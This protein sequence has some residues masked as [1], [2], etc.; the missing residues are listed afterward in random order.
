MVLPSSASPQQL[1]R[2]M[3]SGDQQAFKTLWDDWAHKVQ[4]FVRVQL[5]PSG[6]DAEHCAQEVVADVFHDL[7]RHPERFDG[8]VA[9]NTWLFTVARNKAIDRLRQHQRRSVME[10]SAGDEDFSDVPDDAPT[11]E[12]QLDHR[13]QRHAVMRCLERLRNHLQ[14]EAL[15][16]WAIDD[17]PLAAIASTQQCPENTVKTRLFHGRKNLHSCLQQSLRIEATTP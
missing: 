3:Q 1:L 17:M 15:L 4:F 7:W 11:P 9:F 16:L 8:R 2:A 10:E 5:Q 12:V 6:L 13:Q 14:R